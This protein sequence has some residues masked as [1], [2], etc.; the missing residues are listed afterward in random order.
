MPITG[1]SRFCL[2]AAATGG[3]VASM[4]FRWPRSHEQDGF[5]QA[6]AR[7]TETAVAGRPAQG[8]RRESDRVFLGGRIWRRHARTGAPVRGDPAAVVS[9]FS[10][11][12]R[13]DQGSLSHGLSR[14]AREWMGEAARRPFAADPRAV[15]GVLQR[16]YECDLQP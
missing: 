9:L 3:F 8:I 7:Q 16:L 10:E 15:A 12:G 11:Q 5:A 4:M 14:A 6:R 13:S 2:Y 1:R